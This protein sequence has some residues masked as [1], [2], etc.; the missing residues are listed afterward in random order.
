VKIP[1]PVPSVVLLALIVGPV[2]VA[3]QTP[4]A[5]IAPPPSVEIFPPDTADVKVIEVVAVVVRIGAT[6]AIV[7]KVNSSP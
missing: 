1:A 4:L 5:V 3:Q 2:V 7:V 6:I